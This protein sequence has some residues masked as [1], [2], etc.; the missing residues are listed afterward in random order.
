[1]DTTLLGTGVALQGRVGQ[2]RRG[3]YLSLNSLSYYLNLKDDYITLLGKSSLMK[4]R[5]QM[6]CLGSSR[7]QGVLPTV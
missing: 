7:I 4:R 1:M 5:A 3:I 6:W 2:G